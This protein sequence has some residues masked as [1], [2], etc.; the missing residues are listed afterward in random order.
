[1]IFAGGGL[2]AVARFALSSMTGRFMGTDFPWG[3]LAVNV[4]GA[5][6]IGVLI[7]VFA[8]RFSVS[9]QMR[10]FL[11]TGFLGGFTTFSAFSLEAASMIERGDFISCAAYIAASVAGTIILVLASMWFVRQVL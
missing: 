1:M 3:T 4:L 11:V 7:E 5:L 9:E 2:G 8:L 6:V 10:F